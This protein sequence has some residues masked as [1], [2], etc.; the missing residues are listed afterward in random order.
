M[1]VQSFLSLTMS[2]E[3]W[4]VLELLLNETGDQSRNVGVREGLVGSLVGVL[5]VVVGVRVVEVVVLGV[6]VRILEV[7]LID[8]VIVL[9][10]LIIVAVGVGDV[11]LRAG[12]V[13]RSVVDAVLE[14]GGLM[15]RR[16]R[17]ESLGITQMLP[18]KVNTDRVLKGVDEPSDEEGLVDAM[19]GSLGIGDQ[20]LLGRAHIR[21]ELGNRGSL[22]RCSDEVVVRTKLG[23]RVLTGTVTNPGPEIIQS[24]G[25]RAWVEGVPAAAR[26]ADELGGHELDAI[27][28]GKVRGEVREVV[29][30]V[31]D[32]VIRVDLG[33][34]KRETMLESFLVVLEVLK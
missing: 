15:Y 32:E 27:S 8:V 30:E 19:Q 26:L 7:I 22:S 24:L 12:V 9:K 14:D 1:K 4:M 17:S 5:G 23:E 10:F 21:D 13:V 6:I 33:V 28:R 34:A 3:S 2:L 18:A 25:A 16:E 31:G 20:A 29:L 11:S